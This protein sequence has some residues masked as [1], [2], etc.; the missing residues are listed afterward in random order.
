MRVADNL[1]TGLRSNVADVEAQI[2]L[3]VGD[4]PI[5]L[6]RGTGDVRHSL[7]D[8]N[9][10]WR[11]LGYRAQVRFQEGLRRTVDWYSASLAGKR[12]CVPKTPEF[13]VSR[14]PEAFPA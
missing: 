11:V 14:I 7:A 2:E 3:I 1:S 13:A 4:W 5:P 12:Q 10:A 8:I 6:S 9:S